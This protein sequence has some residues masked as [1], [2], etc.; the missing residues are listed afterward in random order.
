MP[1]DTKKNKGVLFIAVNIVTRAVCLLIL[2]VMFCPNAICDAANKDVAIIID[3]FG[4]NVKG[5]DAFLNGDIPVTVAIMP[6]MPYSTEQAI[7]AHENGLEVIIHLPLEPKNGKASWLGS[8]GITVDLSNDEINKRLREAY[9][10]IPYAVGLNNHMGSKAMEDKRVVG[11]IVEFAKTNGLYLVDSKTTPHSVMPELALKAQ[12]PC[13]ENKL[14]LDDTFSNTQQVQ[15]KMQTFATKGNMHQH[16]IA[17]GHVGV[18]GEQTY[19]GIKAGLPHLK[20]QGYKL[21]F[22]SAWTNSQTR[23]HFTKKEW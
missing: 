23:T 9:E 13:F 18:K 14:F 1:I 2:L 15:G 3:D 16:P 22:P 7:A 20:K 6:N 12:I 17:I 19:A 4:G 5:V 10:Q 8:N 11:L 21:V